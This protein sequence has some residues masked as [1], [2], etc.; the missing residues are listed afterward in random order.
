MLTELGESFLIKIVCAPPSQPHFSLPILDIVLQCCAHPDYDLPDVTF[1]LWYRLSE[2]LYTRNDDSLVAVFKSHVERLIVSL[3]RHC[4]MEPDLTGILEEG[5]DFTEF[6][7]RVTELIKDCVFIVGSSTVFRQ[8]FSQL[9]Q[10]QQWEQTEAALYVMAAVARNILPEE[11]TV[12]PAVLQQ[13]LSLPSSI[14][15]AVRH[16]A[17]KL[18]GELCE[19]IERHPDTLQATL[20]YL[21]QGLQDPRLA[22]EAATALQ[23]VCSQCRSRMAEHFSGL[24]QILEQI[25]QFNLKPEAANG[26]IKGVV[27]IISI[28]SQEQL[29]GAVE[30]VCM[31][32]V[33]PL[34]KCMDSASSATPPK[35]VKHSTTDPVL[36][37]DRLSAVFRHV[38]PSN[39]C[40]PGATAH[41]CKSVV[42]GIWPVLSRSLHLYQDDV[43]V[44]ERTCRTVRFAIR[45]IGI[46]SSSLL[47]P[48]VTQLVGLYEAKGHSCY[49]YLGSILV[50]EYAS[51]QGCI[52]GLLAM[53]Q[54][55][56]SPTYRLLAPKGSLK[57]HPDTV[58]DFFRLN[59]RFLQRAPMPY[60]QVN[61]IFVFIMCIN[62]FNY[63]DFRPRSS[64]PSWSAPCSPQPWSTAMPTPP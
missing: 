54:A 10:T 27:M 36:Y 63:C 30:K 2:E 50:D 6:R 40:P 55:F 3:C 49:L 37:L 5:E 31:L 41:P 52:P 47:E 35:I 59:A 29:C 58:D 15:L 16:T 64:S 42:E 9:Q 33:T 32:Q 57:E 56:I 19:W 39:G 25:D 48:L 12:V 7:V 1:N 46:Q 11:E 34:N 28:M 60:L 62:D 17:I 18:V 13:V 8:M 26:L 45:C 44:T 20:N 4:Q 22:S 23:A 53:L 51:E 21:L 61:I 43:R 38:Q 24:L 14:H